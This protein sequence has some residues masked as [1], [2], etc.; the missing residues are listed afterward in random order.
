MGLFPEQRDHQRY[1]QRICLSVVGEQSIYQFILCS[2]V[3]CLAQQTSVYQTSTFSS[4]GKLPS[5][6]LKYQTTTPQ[7]LFCLQVKMVFKVK[8]SG[9]W[10]SYK[11]SRPFPCIHIIKLC[12]TFS[13]QSFS[14]EFNSQTSQKNLK[15][16]SKCL[17]LE[18]GIDISRQIQLYPVT[19]KWPGCF[20]TFSKLLKI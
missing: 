7:I 8:I 20:K 6:P 10:V 15:A 1:L 4:P 19:Q 12:L 11:F 2:M 17:P 3:I 14:C 13:C 18:L 16:R 9:V 5:S